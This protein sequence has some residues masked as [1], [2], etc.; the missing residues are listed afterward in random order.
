MQTKTKNIVILGAGF[1]GLRTA[2]DLAT[3]L[4]KE[5]V[6][7]YRLILVDQNDTHLYRADL[8]E[9]ATAFNEEINEECLSSL[10]ETVATPIKKLIDGRKIEFRCTSVESIKPKEKQVI[11]RGNQKIDYEYLVVA[12]G[13]V[14]NYFN[15]PGLKERSFPLK[16]IQDA[17]A[18]N[19]HLDQYFQ[20]LWKKGE[21]RTVSIVIGGGG[22]SGVETASELVHSLDKLCKKYDYHRGNV[23]IKL[24]E[25]SQS[26]AAFD[27]EG[28]DL[29][30]QKF[31]KLGIEVHLGSK[32]TAVEESF[33]EITDKDGDS[34]SSKG[35]LESDMV[36][37]TGG[38]MVNPVVSDSL[39]DPEKGGALEVND[40]LESKYFEGIFAA[41]DNAFFEDPQSPGKRLPMLATTACRQ[42]AIVA[43]NILADFHGTARTPYK[44]AE[45][46]YLIPVGGHYVLWQRTKKVSRGY[47]V[48]LIRRL[49]TLKYY[50]SIL[51]FPS[52]LKNW[53]HGSR[54]FSSND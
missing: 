34:P 22:A 47:W 30:L 33:I 41:G 32:I 24:V 18:I 26:L 15:I 16:T 53:L 31:A 5:S 39:G 4:I 10:K 19:C 50:T 9:V 52:A 42:G 12:L 3:G 43:K 25:S 1:A 2:Q 44:H 37:W 17:L 8:Y 21:K 38:V 11:L 28:T 20:T 23:K 14:T 29:I 48:W 7:H 13:S 46:P 40:F 54:V 45:S 51:P 27:K 35:K 6:D 36:I 49:L